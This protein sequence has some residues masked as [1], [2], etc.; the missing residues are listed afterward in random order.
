MN[1]SLITS[2]SALGKCT[3]FYIKVPTKRLKQLP[4]DKFQ[5]PKTMTIIR[6]F[7]HEKA[8]VT[9]KFNIFDI[10]CMYDN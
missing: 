3:N 7:Q 1:F 9:A 4:I 2:Y 6:E 10:V 5:N 8:K